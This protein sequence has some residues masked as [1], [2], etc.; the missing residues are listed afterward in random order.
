MAELLA[1]HGVAV[2][3]RG[4]GVTGLRAH[5]ITNLEAPYDLVRKMRAS[6]LVAGPLL[7]RYGEA[8]VSQPGGCAIGTR[9]IDLHLRA[10]EALGAEVELASGY[11]LMRAPKGLKGGVIRFPFVSVGAT[12]NALMAA[13]LA[14]GRTVIENAAQE[15]EVADL[16]RCLVAMGAKIEGIG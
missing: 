4:N 10:F 12:E 13:S 8:K 7:A 2:T 16:A 9:P 1:N 5:D 15:P 11:V 6:F 14:T 3:P